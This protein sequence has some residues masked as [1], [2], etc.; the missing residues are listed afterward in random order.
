MTAGQEA[1]AA[2]SAQGYR[3]VMLSGVWLLYFCFG[4]TVAALGPL[5]QAI[6]SDLGISHSAMGSVM[7]AWPLVYIAAAMPCGALLDRFGPRRVLLFAGVIIALSGF[8]R[9]AADSHPA[10]F[11]A[12]AVFG[13]GGPLVSIGAP[14]VISTW[15]EGKERGFAMGIYM[16]GMS[17]GAIS[18]LSLTNSVMMPLMGGD[19]RAVLTAYG[20]AAL[21]AGLLWFALASHPAS[22]AVERAQAAEPRPPQLQVFGALLRLPAV[23]L[24]LVMAICIFFFN[25]GLNNWLPEIL[26]GRGMSAAAAGYWAAI[27][28]AVGILG[29]LV[30]PRLAT[31]PRR[32]G[33]LLAV[34]ACA[35]GATLLLQLMPGIGLGTGLVLQGIARGSMMTLGLLILVEV[36]EVGS[37]HAGAAGGLFFSAAEIGGVLGPLTIGVVYDA[38]GGFTSGLF[39]LTAVCALLILL[40]SRLRRYH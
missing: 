16:T 39:L 14:K 24:L 8:L 34:F 33:I 28:T 36:P 32:L 4:L 7:G 37:R 10:L 11:L 2:P 26:R 12:V 6:V 9:G 25:H 1:V 20:A 5:V 19:W 22:R 23:R 17:L 15:F 18:S 38:T 29:A 21:G 27:P 35:A 13:L 3:W 31:P 30:I 40:L